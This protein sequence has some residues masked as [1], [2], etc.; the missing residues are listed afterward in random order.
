MLK[1]YIVSERL[2][3]PVLKDAYFFYTSGSQPFWP[4]D[5]LFK[6]NIRWTTLHYRRGRNGAGR[7]GNSVPTL[8]HV[9]LLNGF[10]AVLKRL[11]FW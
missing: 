8:F 5:Q 4:T 9:L 10:E 7:R 6:N 2:G 3:T 1:G 11:V